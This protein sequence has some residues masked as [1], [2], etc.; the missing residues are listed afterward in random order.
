MK[1]AAL[2]LAV[3]ATPAFVGCLGSDG[4]GGAE[5]LQ[6][7]DVAGPD[8]RAQPA[9]IALEDAKIRPGVDIQTPTRLC[10]SNFVFIRP[11]NTSVFLG[12]TANCVRDMHIG[13]LVTVGGNDTLGVL[14]YSSWITMDEIGEAD[15]DARNYN[16]FAVV[17]IDTSSRKWVHPA[18][19]HYGG[20][21]AM[22][23]AASIAP[24]DRVRSYANVSVEQVASFTGAG[25]STASQPLPSE[26]RQHEGV[27]TARAGEWAYLA[28]ALLPGMPGG[29]GG[30][31]L[32]EEGRAVGVM[33]NLGVRPN[34]ASNGIARLDTLMA[35]AKEHAKLDMELM[36]WDLL[37]PA[38]GPVS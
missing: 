26:A 37:Q 28:Y 25:V 19:L 15:E 36:T 12:T 21:V 4:Q 33:V 5:P 11:D 27:I 38:T 32:D 2:L 13:G 3:L 23:D 22:A 34:P 8:V 20:P 1:A 6:R 17:K 29:M 30:G 35:Y 31:V 14:V 16:D 9:W 24:G 10:P 7:G 18:M